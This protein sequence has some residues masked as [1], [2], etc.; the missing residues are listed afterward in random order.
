MQKILIILKPIIQLFLFV[1]C[2]VTE[3]TNSVFR[4]MN[5]F[6]L[7]CFLFYI[8]FLIFPILYTDYYLKIFT[9][10]YI[11]Q[12][13]IITCYFCYS[14]C[15]S[16]EFKVILEKMSIEEK[17]LYPEY[18]LLIVD[19]LNKLHIVLSISCMIFGFF[20]NFIFYLFGI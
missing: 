11:A 13:G 20:L 8:L 9:D 15:Y 5:N 12:V 19:L 18:A 2:R 7:F 14:T 10:I 1:D 4:S 16:W 3:D 17:S 6:F